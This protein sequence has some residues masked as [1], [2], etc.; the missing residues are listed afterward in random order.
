MSF[1]IT[2]W[3]VFLKYLPG[4]VFFFSFF[5]CFLLRWIFFLLLFRVIHTNWRVTFNFQN[6]RCISGLLLCVS[7]TM[8]TYLTT[9]R[10]KSLFC[11]TLLIFFLK[12]QWR[13]YFHLMHQLI[14]FLWTWTGPSSDLN[15]FPVA[16]GITSYVNLWQKQ[17]ISVLLLP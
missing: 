3:R 16:S 1:V 11:F 4:K 2:L 15:I 9:I 13:L 10:K 7:H 8:F 6:S 14:L 5:N 12:R 17:V